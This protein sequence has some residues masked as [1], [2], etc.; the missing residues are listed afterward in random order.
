MK[1]KKLL[2][3][4]LVAVMSLGLLA[5][6]QSTGTDGTTQPKADPTKAPTAAPTKAPTAAPTEAPTEA[7]TDPPAEKKTI[8]ISWIG[9]NWRMPVLPGPGADIMNMLQER[10]KVELEPIFFPSAEFI[11]QLRLLYTSGDL[12]DI[13][14][15]PG[16]TE[17]ATLH[18]EELIRE[19]PLESI[20]K[21]A[22][23][24]WADMKRNAA[25][26]P[27]ALT[28]GIIDGKNWGIPNMNVDATYREVVVW[29]DDWLK[30]VGITKIPETIA[31]FEDALYKI[32]QADPQGTDTNGLH[33]SGLKAI[34]GAYRDPQ[35]FFVENGK[36]GNGP[37]DPLNKEMLTMLA[38]WYKDGIL[39]KDFDEQFAAM[40]ENEPGTYWPLSQVFHR[41]KVAM[42]ALGSSY[43]WEKPHY[44]GQENPSV[45]YTALK[46]ENPDATYEFGVPAK[47]P[48]GNQGMTVYSAT[49]TLSYMS[50][51]VDQEKFE[52]IL[53][54]MEAMCADEELYTKVLWAN[55]G[56]D[57]D[58]DDHGFVIN[59]VKDDWPV[60]KKPTSR[61]ANFAFVNYNTMKFH[62]KYL[63]HRYKISDKY[64]AD[65]CI[66][67]MPFASLPSDGT[68]RQALDDMWR[69]FYV[70]VI[71]GD[72]SVD[73]FDAF[74]QRYNDAGGLDRL[75]E[76]QEAYD[77]ADSLL[78]YVPN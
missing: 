25:S 73:E 6:C 13:F 33:C 60:E 4:L 74:V 55:K 40:T 75:A 45:N 34:Y 16:M 70:E 69:E 48:T 38:K 23:E 37:T 58:L 67:P 76:A 62:K 63:S 46:T 21:L 39:A 10:F 22:P 19:I 27:F 17:L 59:L 65:H 56:E 49:S 28:K 66:P 53:E 51:K 71:K 78:Q 44:E 30:E 57:W 50:H 41:G 2:V 29:R 64:T 12:P 61:G 9:F 32:V 42:T 18:K 77:A 11:T 68:T 36:L 20:K 8:K 5:A 1:I 54:M 31:E 14:R 7:P 15:V 26:D 3:V 52:R 24:M 35:F 43:H 47:G 72:K